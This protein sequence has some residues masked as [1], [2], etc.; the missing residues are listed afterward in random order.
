MMER[1]VH[2]VGAWHGRA[3]PFVLP[4][5]PRALWRLLP[6][7][8]AKFGPP[9]RWA[10]F[11]E[12]ARTHEV[13]WIPVVPARSGEFPRPFWPVD[14]KLPF[15]KGRRFAW[16]EQGVALLNEARVISSDGWCVDKED[17]FIGDFCFRGNGR[18]SSVYALKLPHAPQVLPGVT[19][20][21]CSQ[22]AA[23]NF[24]HWALDAVARLELVDRAG[25]ARESIDHVLLPRFPGATADW[26]LA[27]LGI[28]AEKL[29]HPGRRDQYRCER[30]VQPSYPGEVESYPPWV[31]EFYRRNF[32]APAVSSPGRKLYFP[33]R[34]KRRLANE[35]E[36][37]AE[38]MKHGFEAFEPA[39]KTDLHVQLAD[40]SHVV[41]IHGAALTNL[42]FC[43]TGTRVLELLPSDMPWRHFYSLCS[44]AGMPYGVV[45]GKSIRERRSL[46]S[47]ATDTPFHLPIA[48]LRAAL[49][50]LLSDG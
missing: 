34:G 32:P 15:L 50:E 39:G 35:T 19:L 9:R 22:H 14:G 25:L 26:I 47:A 10:S 2:R 11:N 30:L 27:S 13:G 20:N 36:V 18:S 41:G 31:V 21:L 29:I 1:L 17:T 43:R 3:L 7:S 45:L 24:C 44:S 46:A 28:P 23:I 48:E 33:R 42:I 16:P 38:L 12:Y 40:V 4:V 49:A 6:G 5:I 8:S 37:E